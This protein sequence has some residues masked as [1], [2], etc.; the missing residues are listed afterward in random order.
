M[1]YCIIRKVTSARTANVA[2]MPALNPFLHQIL[3]I[4]DVFGLSIDD[5]QEIFKCKD[6]LFSNIVS[7]FQ[8]FG[9]ISHAKVLVVL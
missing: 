5:G 8:S 9:K 6:K 3:L 2:N 1:S 4:E 7:V